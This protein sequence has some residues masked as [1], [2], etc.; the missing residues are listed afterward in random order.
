MRQ[1]VPRRNRERQTVWGF[2]HVVTYA[3]DVMH[4]LQPRVVLV[5]VALLMSARSVGAQVAPIP[6]STDAPMTLD[7]VLLDPVEEP[8]K[9]AGF[10]SPAPEAASSS[11]PAWREEVL[12][13]DLL[14]RSY[15]ANPKD[16][17]LSSRILHNS[18]EGFI[19]ALEA[20][21]RVGVWRYGTPSGW[22]NP[23]TGR[24]EGWQVDIQ[25]A[26]FPRLNF[27]EELDVDAVDFKVGVPLTYSKGQWE[28]KVSWYHLS[29]HVGDE[30]LIRNPG[31]NRLNY[32]RDAFTFGGGYY[33]NPDLRLYGEA[34]YSYNNDGGSDPW[35]LH[36]GF[37]WMPASVNPSVDKPSPFLAVHGL[38]REEH[39]FGGGVNIVAGL[40]W[41]GPHS[42]KLFRAGIQYY[43]GKSWQ[44]SF[45]DEH[46]ELL[47]LSLWYDF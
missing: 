21:A 7:S 1:N 43:N 17:R 30:F 15:I 29:S 39:D 37:D 23:Y 9:T 41:R 18:G 8:I 25:G 26:A 35:H 4:R 14:Y 6:T 40:Q 13:A 36:V 46:E 28:A 11:F 2:T 42:D 32:L 38:L 31:F 27:E 5:A 34:E 16:A 47:G 33:A 44:F 20:G 22:R 24:P 45:V 12:P 3:G 19:W 10:T